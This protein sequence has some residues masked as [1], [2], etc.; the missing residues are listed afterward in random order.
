MSECLS[1]CA[2]QIKPI[3]RNI[4]AAA[5]DHTVFS[6]PPDIDILWKF[7]HFLWPAEPQEPT[8]GAFSY[9]V[10]ASTV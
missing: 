10:T 8:F 6:R 1:D 7:K 3:F 4:A 9:H 2:V 5:N